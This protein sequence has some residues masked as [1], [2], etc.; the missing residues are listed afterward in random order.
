[1]WWHC[2][3]TMSLGRVNV[4]QLDTDVCDG[5]YDEVAFCDSQRLWQSGI[6]RHLPRSFVKMLY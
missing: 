2:K 5:C 1:V 3:A 6:E 4:T